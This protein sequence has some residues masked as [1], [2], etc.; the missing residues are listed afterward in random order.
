M[1][2]WLTNCSIEKTKTKPNSNSEIIRLFSGEIIFGYPESI[3][4]T[5][6]ARVCCRYFGAKNLYKKCACKTL[7]KL[8]VGVNFINISRARFGFGK[9]T[10]ALSYKILHFRMK[11]TRVKCWWNWLP[12]SISSTFYANIFHTKVLFCQNL[13]R[14]MLRKALL[15]EQLTSKMLIIDT[16]RQK[17]IVVR[18]NIT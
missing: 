12:V 15:Y 16:W 9:S 18:K 2:V 11:N 1:S 6:Y 14:E 5:F 13:T 4:S 7:M 17:K 8:T 10:K 3:S